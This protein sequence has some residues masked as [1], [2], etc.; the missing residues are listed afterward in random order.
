MSRKDNK[1]VARKLMWFWEICL[2]TD[3]TNLSHLYY[4]S[5]WK[6]TNAPFP[7]RLSIIQY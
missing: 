7:E 1:K 3:S 5:I 2:I 4:T 6:T